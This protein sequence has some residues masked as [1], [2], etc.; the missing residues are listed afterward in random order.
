MN[1]TY[2]S[3][4]A[5]ISISTEAPSSQ[6]PMSKPAMS[7]TYDETEQGISLVVIIS[8]DAEE[9]HHL[10]QPIARLFHT[11]EP[12]ELRIEE[13]GGARRKGARAEPPQFRVMAAKK[14]AT[15]RISSRRA[16]PPC[17]RRR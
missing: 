2:K 13:R 10:A 16:C 14:A 7:V 3:K 5:S 17:I 8:E 9:I 4:R 12:E 15:K 11:D 6:E 1:W